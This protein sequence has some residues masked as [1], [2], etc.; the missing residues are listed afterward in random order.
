ML[1]NDNNTYNYHGERLLYD[2]HQFSVRMMG[3][4]IV[5]APGNRDVPY[6]TI[7]AITYR[8]RTCVP[9]T[10]MHV[11]HLHIIINILLY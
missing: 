8:R 5:R 3:S 9:H 6:V 2:T 10:Y 11:Q 1:S 7:I 4:G